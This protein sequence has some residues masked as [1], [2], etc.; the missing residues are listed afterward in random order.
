MGK[1][2]RKAWI[3]SGGVVLVILLIGWGIAAKNNPAFMPVS[4]FNKEKV[5][6]NNGAQFN[7]NTGEII[8]SATEAVAVLS[9]ERVA[10]GEYAND[11]QSA[12]VFVTQTQE[13]RI[14]VAYAEDQGKVDAD[15]IRTYSCGDITFVSKRVAR[16]AV[17]NN[18][19]KALFAGNV[20]TDFVP[21]NVIPT[22]PNLKFTHAT[23]SNGVAQIYLTGSFSGQSDGWCGAELAMAQLIETAKAFPSIHTVEIYQNS[24][25]IY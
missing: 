6:E 12:T 7:E 19:I 3:I 13:V 14:A 11:A 9:P 1:I 2:T 21:G 15:D 8:E 18:A 5:E 16:P 22:H 17:L 24:A 4:L 25:K 10:N 23:I 20:L